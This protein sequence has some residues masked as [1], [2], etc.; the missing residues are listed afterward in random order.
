MRKDVNEVLAWCEKQRRESKGG[1]KG[2]CQQ[3]SREAWG[4]PAWAPS[5]NKA[6]ALIPP[7]HRHHTP[8]SEVPPGALCFGL[9]SHTYGHA[10][11]AG[12]NGHGYSIDYK[13]SGQVDRVPLNLPHWTGDT[14][15]WWTDVAVIGGK[16]VH[17]PLDAHH[18][19]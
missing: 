8:V 13:R 5:A 11:I 6:W 4:L 7:E 10:W 9:F 16:I 14:K 12:R 19:G 1:R 2:L 15:V 3:M 18:R 17:L